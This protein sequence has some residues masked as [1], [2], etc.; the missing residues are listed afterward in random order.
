MCEYDFPQSARNRLIMPMPLGLTKAELAAREREALACLDPDTVMMMGDNPK[1]PQMPER[2]TLL[3]FFRHRVGGLTEQHLLVSAQRALQAGLDE[4][5]VLAVLLHDISVAALIRSDH[6]HWG[7]QMIAP[8][9][10]D[11][12][13][14]A[15]KYHQCLRYFAD[16]A[17][18]Y[19][20]PD[21]YSRFFGADFQPPEHVRREAEFARGHKWYMSA[22]LVT[23]Y[24]SYFFDE[25]PAPDPEIFADII[26]RHFRQPADG[27]GFDN[28]PSAH[29]WR[30]LIWPHNA[31]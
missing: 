6:G 11:E 1:L 22:R 10:D 12:V 30:T 2:P 15:V 14:F 5:M 28:S 23:I 18:G 27:L 8:Y 17:N 4:K 25:S 20:Y 13:T 9:V 19:A 26:G 7:A 3:D 24:D 16:E 29:M 21:S 31:L